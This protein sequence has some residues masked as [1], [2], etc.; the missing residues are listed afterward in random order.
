MEKSTLS[1]DVHRTRTR[2]R[3]N[4]SEGDSRRKQILEIGR[5]ERELI[6]KSL[7]LWKKAQAQTEA[8]LGQRGVRSI[9]RPA[10]AVWAQ[11]GRT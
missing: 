4:A 2:G 9:H 7:P 3:P 8:M 10:N 1:R 6:E 5:C 11:L